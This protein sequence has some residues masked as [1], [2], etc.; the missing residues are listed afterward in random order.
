M[1][2]KREVSVIAMPSTSRGGHCTPREDKPCAVLGISDFLMTA[3][4][5]RS[6][7]IGSHLSKV[8]S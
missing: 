8:S 7:E 4:G 2:G 3:G 1:R 5:Q 6:P